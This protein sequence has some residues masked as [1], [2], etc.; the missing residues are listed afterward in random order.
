MRSW[1]SPMSSRNERSG[2]RGSN[3]DRR[4]PNDGRE[5]PIEG[6][7]DLGVQKATLLLQA[8]Q[9]LLRLSRPVKRAI[10]LGAD[11]L[12]LPAA[13]LLAYFLKF[14]RWSELLG[15]SSLIACAIVTGLLAFLILGFYRTVIR[16]M[17][18][19]AIGKMVLGATLSVLGLLVCET[20]G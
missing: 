10:M 20:L 19:K 16:F 9:A 2:Y 6:G 15:M 8:S 14:D 5:Q 18:M 4:R 1:S 3:K 17:G 13:L 11:A 7:M 12:M